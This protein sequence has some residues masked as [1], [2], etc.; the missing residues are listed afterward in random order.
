M[1]MQEARVSEPSG[2]QE[3]VEVFFA[4]Y[5]DARGSED[6]QWH[7]AV[8]G[9]DGRIS[10]LCGGQWEEV[11]ILAEVTRWPSCKACAEIWEDVR[12]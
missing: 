1:K 9:R 8:D 3:E 11:E 10:A 5:S 12:P 7:I 4:P 2:V 6:G